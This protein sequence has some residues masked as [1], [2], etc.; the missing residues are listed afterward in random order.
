MPPLVQRSLA[1]VGAIVTAPA[2][3]LLAVAIRLETPGPALYRARRVGRGGRLFSCLKLRT[4]SLADRGPAI[5]AKGDARI[6]GTG[7]F[8]RR[9]RL[10]ELPQL[11]NVVRGEM[12]LVGPRPEDPRFIDIDDPLHRTVFTATPGITG[13][14]QLLFAQERDLLDPTD[15]EGSYRRDVLPAKLLLDARYLARR[16][17]R[18]DAWIL[19][20]TLAAVIGRGPSVADV[21]AWL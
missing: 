7:A 1:L 15:P 6:T 18:L 9:F 21:E 3:A 17:T 14:A 8:I 10:D 16:S 19:W 2:I 5:T 12:L 20:S 13:A 4:M 11:W